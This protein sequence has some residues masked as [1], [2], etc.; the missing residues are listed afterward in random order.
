MTPQARPAFD[1]RRSNPCKRLL[2]SMSLFILLCCFAVSKLAAQASE[3]FDSYKIRIEGLWTYSNPSGSLRGSSEAGSID[4]VKDLG[5]NSYN[6]FMG[7]LDWK[8]TRKNHLY[9]LGV[10]LHS[11]RET[12]VTRTIT[13]QGQTFQA[14]IAVQSSLDS[15]M[16]GFGYQYDIIRRKRGHLGLAAQLNLFD[17]QASIKAVAQISGGGGGQQVT[18][19]ASGS[20]IAPVPVAGPQFRLYLSDSPRVFVE[21]LAAPGRYD[22]TPK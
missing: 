20:L 15:P 1:T 19:S 3:D 11:S 16:Y 21:D 6:T 22:L 2:R 8:F 4:L 5:F 7:K 17:S 9:V 18:Q 12:A 14:G 13:F 10:P